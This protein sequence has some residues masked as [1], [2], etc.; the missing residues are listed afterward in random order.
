[1]PSLRPSPA[2][3]TTP[4]IPSHRPA[5]RSGWGWRRQWS[6][7]TARSCRRATAT[8]CIGSSAACSCRAAC[9]ARRCASPIRRPSELVTVASA[10]EPTPIEPAIPRRSARTP[11]RGSG[12]CAASPRRRSTAGFPLLCGGHPVALLQVEA[13]AAEELSAATLELLEKLARNLSL[14]LDGLEHQRHKHAAEQALLDN[15]IRFRDAAGAAGEYVWE[16]DLEGHFTYL[17]EGIEAHQRLSPRG[18][19]RAQAHRPHAGGGSQPRARAGSRRTWGRTARSATS[20]ISSSP[21][22]AR[23]AG[24]A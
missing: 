24:C 14:A 12:D 15:A 23:C 11:R 16:V 18:A 22:M 21:G 10:G 8:P 1:M 17:S 19:G 13:H 20:S 7:R 4:P 2:P 5:P 3:S 6:M 9:A